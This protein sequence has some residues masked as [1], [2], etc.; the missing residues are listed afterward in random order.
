M[1]QAESVLI[2][3]ET[4]LRNRS[5]TVEQLRL[6]QE[7]QNRFLELCKVWDIHNQDTSICRKA[8]ASLKARLE[9]MRQYEQQ[10]RLDDIVVDEK[11]QQ[12]EAEVSEANQM[13]ERLK[14]ELERQG[15]EA[16]GVAQHNKALQENVG[17][18]ES[19]LSSADAALQ[20]ARQA[21]ASLLQ[22]RLDEEEQEKKTA[23]SEAKQEVGCLESELERQEIEAA[24]VAQHNEAL[25]ENVG[26]LELQLSNA[27]P[28][29]QELNQRVTFLQKELDEKERE[30]KTS[31]SEAKQEVGRLESELERQEIEAA[32]V[33][34]HNEALQE[35]VGELEL[36][37][38]NA[39]AALQELN[40]RVT[41][42]QKE[43]DEKEREKKTAVSEA[44]KEVGRLESEL[45]RQEIEAAGVAQHNKAL[46]K[47]VGE[48]ESR[49]SSADAAL[50]EAR[51][52]VAS[53]QRRLDEE[54]QEKKTAVSEAKQEVG[55]LESELERQEIEAAGVAQHNKA[56]Q[57]NVGELESQLSIANAALLQELNLRVAF[58]QK[59]LDEKELEKKTAEQ[60]TDRVQSELERQ[61]NETS[62]VTQLQKDVSHL[63]L[64][65]SNAES[66]ID[67]RKESEE[68]LTISS[69]NIQLSSTKLGEG[70][71]AG[72]VSPCIDHFHCE[73]VSFMYI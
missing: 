3:T 71:Y 63:E 61:R 49:L 65:L 53:L 69:Q 26:E 73:D 33:A 2:T 68:G 5:I 30:K 72:L 60:E 6:L 48:L 43:L 66:V 19:R 52:A 58:L 1:S 62:R 41:F 39:N 9:E 28:A 38:S 59:E 42:L 47:N 36:Q 45:E 23:V 15:R 16:A 11:E 50:Q 51:Q 21:V 25:Q 14:S 32:S 37:L 34:Q 27:N 12:K 44:K 64:L 56:L 8:K 40:Q 55:R 4:R 70:S 20:E 13:V 35:N 22:R 24:G 18:L 67:S 29:L 31:V 57:K 10:K 7:N 46:Q 17:G 54:E